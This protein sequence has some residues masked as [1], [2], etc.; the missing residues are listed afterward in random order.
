M[1]STVCHPQCV[2]HSVATVLQLVWVGS[3][4]K[5]E[6]LR[7]WHLVWQRLC[8]YLI[9]WYT[10]LSTY[11]TKQ[12]LIVEL[13]TRKQSLTSATKT[14]H[15]GMLFWWRAL[16]GLLNTH[17]SAKR[18]QALVSYHINGLYTLVNANR[19]S[20]PCVWM[21]FIASF[22]MGTGGHYITM[23]LADWSI[24]TLHDLL[25][26]SFYCEN[27]MESHHWVSIPIR[28]ACQTSAS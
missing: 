23:M 7:G 1:S 10:I 22:N 21:D 11:L 2:T 17:K 5:F 9:S 6:S 26:S 28:V 25:P 15:W 18:G 24:S 20:A 8:Q 4:S 12:P 27:A 3:S 14:T 16:T 13:T 19:I